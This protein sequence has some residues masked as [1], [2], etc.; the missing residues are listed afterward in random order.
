MLAMLLLKG[1]GITY[2]VAASITVYAS[3]GLMLLSLILNLARGLWILYYR[4]IQRF[5]NCSGVGSRPEG[6]LEALRGLSR[7]L[8]GQYLHRKRFK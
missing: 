5:N 6:F 2:S 8:F 4:K 3:T 7:V 1:R